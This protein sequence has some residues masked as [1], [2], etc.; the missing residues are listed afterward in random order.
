MNIVHVVMVM[1]LGHHGN[2]TRMIQ[3]PV[4]EGRGV[5]HILTHV[6]MATGKESNLAETKFEELPHTTQVIYYP[7]SFQVVPSVTTRI[8]LRDVGSVTMVTV[9]MAT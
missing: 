6:T 8:P 5:D 3:L 4:P 7:S 9:T 1:K 2:A